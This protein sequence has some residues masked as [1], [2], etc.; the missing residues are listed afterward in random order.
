M[1][2]IS[3]RCKY[4]WG[5][6]LLKRHDLVEANKLLAKAPNLGIKKAVP[7]HS[8]G[9]H[10]QPVQRHFSLQTLISCYWYCRYSTHIDLCRTSSTSPYSNHSTPSHRMSPLIVCYYK[11]SLSC[12]WGVRCSL[13]Q[14]H[15][16]DLQMSQS[17]Y[18]H[19]YLCQG[20]ESRG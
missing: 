6:Y 13:Q 14:G 19:A 12:Q 8:A 5:L 10:A 4:N 16:L 15:S 17:D 9:R 20:I 1:F 18:S 3:S 11:L 7:R 2:L